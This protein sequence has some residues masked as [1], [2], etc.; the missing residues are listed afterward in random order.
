MS[1]WNVIDDIDQLLDMIVKRDA[2]I[3]KITSV[4]TGLSLLYGDRFQKLMDNY[5]TV[6]A[7]PGKI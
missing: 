5:E 4:L 1:C 3:E 2:P 7:V 6:H